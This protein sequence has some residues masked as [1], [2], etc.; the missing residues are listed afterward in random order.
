[1]ERTLAILLAL[2]LLVSVLAGCGNNNNTGTNNETSNTPTENTDYE[3]LFRDLPEAEYVTAASDFAGG[4]GTESNPYQISNAAELA[5]LHEKMV[6]EHKELKSEYKSA[7]YILTADITVNDTADFDKWESSAPEYSWMPIGFDAVEFDGVFDGKGY[8]ISGLYINTNCGTADENS[9]NNY[10][11]FDTVDGTVKNIKIDKAYIAVS[12]R[13]CGVG[14]IAGLLM[15]EATVDNCSSNAVLNC[16]DNSCGGIVGI[17]Y[18]G[19]DTGMVDEGEERIINYSTISNCSFTGKITQVK[20]NTMANI[21]GIIGVCDG[22]IDACVNNGTIT[23]AGD[24]VDSVGGI[25]GRVSEGTVSICKNTG[26][27]NCEIK[28][29]KNLAIA[30]GI[31]GKV[32][33]SAAGGEKY[34]SRG[35]KITECENSGTVAGQM[36]AGG[37]AGQIS[38]DHNDYCITVSECVNSG[39]V[40]SKDYTAG[41]IGHLNCLGDAENGDSIVVENCENKADLNKGTVGGIV[42]G[43]MSETG[44]VKIKGCKNSGVLASEGQHCAGIV[45]YWIMNGKPSDSSIV[46]DNCENTGSITSALNAGGIISFMDMPVCLEMGDGVSISISNCINSGDITIDKVNGYIGGILGN[47]GMANVATT[48]DK[49]TNNGTLAI[50]AAADSMTDK[51]AEIMT[52]SRIAGGIVGR[53]GSGLLL[54]TDSDK[55]DEK[56]IQSAHADLKITNSKNTGKLDVVN[57]DAENYKNWF[58]GIIGNTCGEDGF[59]IFVDRCTYTGFDRGLGNENLTDIGTKN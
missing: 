27:I 11:L 25:A 55:A 46:I 3:Y 58:G 38:N 13:T 2:M 47:W 56:N 35:A 37:I 14:S 40:T 30:G 18:G 32:F 5:L 57:I 6:A 15:D 23:F 20:D 48:I 24:N 54:T 1:M 17:A 52:V 4:D 21:G 45:A 59:A 41:I 51:D 34:M 31:V 22:N 42:G 39:V 50:T 53:V 12:G 44:D 49:C 36:Y 43:F 8:T 28:D 9:T 10:G 19:V 26:T 33:V 29:G 7:Y 16:Y